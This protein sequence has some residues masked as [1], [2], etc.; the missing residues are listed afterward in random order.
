M[1]YIPLSSPL[2]AV[3][4]NTNQNT[5]DLEYDLSFD[6]SLYSSAH[7]KSATKVDVFL[8]CVVIGDIRW[9]LSGDSRGTGSLRFSSSGIKSGAQRGY[10]ST[11]AAGGGRGVSNE[12]A[13]GRF[14]RMK[15]IGLVSR[16]V[17]DIYN[18][19]ATAHYSRIVGVLT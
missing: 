10:N 19:N 2:V 12:L 13:I 11:G 9:S 17:F 7:L 5:T 4:S 3:F 14:V 1:S 16:G 6:K 15:E 18:Y 8:Q